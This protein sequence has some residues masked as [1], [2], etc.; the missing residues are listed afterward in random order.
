MENSKPEMENGKPATESKRA[1][2][3]GSAVFHFRF[4]ISGFPC[5]LLGRAPAVRD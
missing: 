1:Q 5:L 4:S 3:C 2:V